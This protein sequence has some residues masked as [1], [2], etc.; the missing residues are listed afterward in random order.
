MIV[1]E[2]AI[3]KITVEIYLLQVPL[4]SSFMK[5]VVQEGPAHGR[6]KLEY[7]LHIAFLSR[8]AK[9]NI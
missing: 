1:H 8:H 6:T 7:G 4:Q 9:H 3:H 5:R 2:T